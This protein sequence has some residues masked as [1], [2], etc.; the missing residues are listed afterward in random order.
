MGVPAIRVLT[1]LAQKFVPKPGA[2]LSRLM[3]APLPLTG[4]SR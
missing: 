4:E 1:I 3:G 2:A